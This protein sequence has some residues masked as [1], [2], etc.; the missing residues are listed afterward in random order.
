MTGRYRDT[1]GHAPLTVRTGADVRYV[2]QSHE[3]EVPLEAGWTELRTA[4][5]ETH[6][7]RFGFSR[8]DEPIEL[9]NLRSVAA[10]EAPM[11]WADLPAVGGERSAQGRE[12]VWQRQT[13]PVGFALH[14]PAIVVEADSAVLLEE[15][16][17]LSVLDDG[18]L[19]IVS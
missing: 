13:L 2:G 18:T 4:F 9:V 5:E 15:D 6:R 17:R 8:A 10:G 16:D 19:E 3:L 14:G 1:F 12:G 11:T 7:Q